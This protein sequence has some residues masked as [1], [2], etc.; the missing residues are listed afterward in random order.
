MTATDVGTLDVDGS[1]GARIEASLVR[2]RLA[3]LI[4]IGLLLY[5]PCLGLWELWYPD[6]PDIGEAAQ[7]MYRSGD[8]VSPRRMGTIWVDYP[9]M[10]YWVG[11]T[12]SH[13]LGDMSPFALRFPNALAAILVA[14]ITCLAG[15]KWFG[16]RAGFWAGFMVLGFRQF[17]QQAIGYRPDILFT[18]GIAGGL[19]LY[20]AGCGE[21]PRWWLRVAG[22]AMLGFAMLSKGPL[23]LLLPGLV[24][25]LWHGSRKEWRRILELAPLALFSLAVYMPWFSACAKAMGSDNILFELYAQ[26]VARFFGGARG[27][28]QPIYYY[29][30]N[31]WVDLYPWAPLL[32]FALWWSHRAGLLRDRNQQLLLWWLGTF[33]VFLSI[34]VTKRELYLLPAYPAAALLLAPWI[35]R[36]GLDETGSPPQPSGRTLR[37]FGRVIAIVLVVLGAI[38]LLVAGPVF[39]TL[40]EEASLEGPEIEAAEAMKLPLVITGM[41]T[42]AAAIWIV[43]ATRQRQVRGVLYSIGGGHLALYLVL[44]LLVLPAANPAKTY[45]PAGEWML[46]QMG[47]STHFGLV[48][49]DGVSG[50][51]KMGAFGYYTG[52]LVELMESPEEIDEF[53]VR[54][55]ASIALFHESAADE[56]LAGDPAAWRARLVRDDL[57]AGGRRYLVVG[58]P[59]APPAPP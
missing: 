9:P 10:L 30:G 55:P 58:R 21:K 19:F 32:P 36:V 48:Y 29:L 59:E 15:S 8:W 42:L 12:S 3:A 1:L 2:H 52:R 57:W 49:S 46:T 31:F 45:R 14:V 16:P 41:T 37:N 50:I 6:E 18:V 40:I 24:L 23:G 35:A 51:H 4:L 7:A 56:F 43:V 22:F 11:V 47:D 39:G 38:A 13:V 28:A 26:N 44:V 20:A 5:V 33:F 25:T 27:H 17:A 53:F 34:A 54:H